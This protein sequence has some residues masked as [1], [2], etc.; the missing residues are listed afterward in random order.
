MQAGF[1]CRVASKLTFIILMLISLRREF[2]EV[3]GSWR[4]CFPWYMLGFE[5]LYHPP[6]FQWNMWRWIWMIPKP[7]ICIDRVQEFHIL[8]FFSFLAWFPAGWEFPH[9]G[10]PLQMP[11]TISSLGIY[12]KMLRRSHSFNHCSLVNSPVI[13]LGYFL[14]GS[15]SFRLPC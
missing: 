12:R 5:L 6:N 4:V 3:L 2:Q 15:L 14:F 1:V 8:R 7:R 9:Q 13:R 11:E 10:I